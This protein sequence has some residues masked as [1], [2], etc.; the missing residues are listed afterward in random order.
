MF[1]EIYPTPDTILCADFEEAVAEIH[2]SAARIFRLC[3]PFLAFSDYRKYLDA[4]TV[5]RAQ[6][7]G[8]IRSFAD[9]G[10]SRIRH[11]DIGPGI[12]SHALYSRSRF[13]SLYCGLEAYP[14]SYQV[15]RSFFRWLARGKAPY[16]DFVAGETFGVPD[17]RLARML[18]KGKQGIFHVPSWKFALI[19][20]CFF[21]LVTATWV[22]NE[23]NLAGVLWLISGAART[24][25]EGGFFYIRDSGERKV[26][27]HDF[28]YD[29]W[30]KRMGF[31]ET[32]RLNVQNRVDFWGVSR[33]YRKPNK[34][35]VPAFDDLVQ[36]VL[37]HFG[38]SAKQNTYVG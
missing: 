33:M 19:D 25:K 9:L 32:G 36:E 1:Y 2:A 13:R 12:G 17:S 22:L 31:E 28:D 20:D 11:L 30:L 7:Y 14:A 26:D 4:M 5:T 16:V 35:V 18:R 29:A 38:E 23:V 10:S 37:G 21:D 3:F 6:D 27:R 15:Q 8:F 34:A 24:L